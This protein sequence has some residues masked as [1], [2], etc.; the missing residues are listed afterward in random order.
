[1]S[2]RLTRQV[3]D[4]S[5]DRQPCDTPQP[6]FI[7]GRAVSFPLAD[8]HL[9]RGDRLV[10]HEGIQAVYHP[11]HMGGH[12]TY[13]SLV[14]QVVMFPPR[15]D[16]AV[17]LKPGGKGWQGQWVW[18]DPDELTVMQNPVEH[19]PDSVS[20]FDT[21]LPR[22]ASGVTRRRLGSP[23]DMFAWLHSQPIP[24][25]VV[26]AFGMFAAQYEGHSVWD[27]DEGQWLPGPVTVNVNEGR[28][29]W[30]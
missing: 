18:T 14:L 10:E 11:D 20:Y 27:A 22:Q 28:E 7:K 12:W 3:V 1:M 24:V 21:D 9:E 6:D 2:H 19:G 17:D 5:Y 15:A 23:D 16:E 26:R 4:P 29:D 25:Q 30:G 8:S 13:A